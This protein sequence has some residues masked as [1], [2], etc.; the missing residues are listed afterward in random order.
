MEVFLFDKNFPNI[1]A[2]KARILPS[3]H[4]S[5]VNNLTIMGSLRYD[6][7]AQTQQRIKD[8]QANHREAQEPEDTLGLI[9]MIDQRF[10]LNS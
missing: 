2:E 9:L 10:H 7:Q 6:S 1:K 8:M 5:L 4:I 3:N